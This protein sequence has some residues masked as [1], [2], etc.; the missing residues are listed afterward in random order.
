MISKLPPDSA[1]TVVHVMIERRRRRRRRG[2]RGRGR[3]RRGRRCC[4]LELQDVVDGL[5]RATIPAAPDH[6]ALV[7]VR[8]GDTHSWSPA[9]CLPLEAGG[10]SFLINRLVAWRV[11]H[12]SNRVRRAAEVDDPLA[13]SGPTTGTV[14]PRRDGTCSAP[15]RHGGGVG[16]VQSV[17][18]QQ[19]FIEP[20][21]L[22]PYEL[23]R[24]RGV[25]IG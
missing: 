13:P 9:A 10:S 22:R 12:A 25:K 7:A 24:W 15:T 3:R 18:L 6:A 17:D 8:A 19:V 4:P 21:E 2:R 5:A 11:A 20:C 23:R 16:G 1:A 14:I